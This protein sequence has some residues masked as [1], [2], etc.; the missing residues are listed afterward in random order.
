MSVPFRQP[1]Y[2]AQI[3]YNILDSSYINSTQGATCTYHF[4]DEFVK[5][6]LQGPINPKIAF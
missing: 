5:Y 4:L 2:K 3:S 6:K 1:W